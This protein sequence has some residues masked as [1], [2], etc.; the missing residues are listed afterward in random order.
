M[1]FAELFADPA[2]VKPSRTPTGRSTSSINFA[3]T[4]SRPSS[5]LLGRAAALCPR[6]VEQGGG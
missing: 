3:P 1:R 6:L 5:G 2:I 4:P